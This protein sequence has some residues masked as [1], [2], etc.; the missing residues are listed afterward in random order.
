MP[1]LLATLLLT[2]LLAG[3][4]VSDPPAGE[5]L[6]KLG[7]ELVPAGAEL[8][9]T[10]EGSCP[11]IAGNPSCARVFYVSDGSEDERADAL[12][13][14][15]RAAGWE[16]VSREPRSDGILVELGRE[17]YRAFAAIWE[18]ERAGPCRE[19]PETDCADELQLIED[20]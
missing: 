18:E 12:E 20:I 17:G 19:Q 6:G 9:E 11:Q 15:A 7:E 4:S 3:C 2:A 13:E 5:R 8:V 16:V 10:N 14:A 1:R